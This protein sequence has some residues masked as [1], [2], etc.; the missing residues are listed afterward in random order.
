VAWHG[1]TL[2]KNPA[3]IVERIRGATA[4]RPA[5]EQ[6]AVLAISEP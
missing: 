6:P 5:L 3:A 2:A 4:Q 1:D